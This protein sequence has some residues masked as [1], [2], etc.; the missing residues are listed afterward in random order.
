MKLDCTAM[1]RGGSATLTLDDGTSVP[2]RVEYMTLNCHYAFLKGDLPDGRVAVAHVAWGG[3]A[4]GYRLGWLVIGTD[5][6]KTLTS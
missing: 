3:G 5:V 6:G 1:G 4:N 2:L